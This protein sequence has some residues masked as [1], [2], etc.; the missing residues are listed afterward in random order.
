MIFAI[1][2]KIETPNL[3]YIEI[4]ALVGGDFCF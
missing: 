3:T 4:P 1:L 2:K